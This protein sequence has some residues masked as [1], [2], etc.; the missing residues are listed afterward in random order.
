VHLSILAPR[1]Y[2]SGFPRGVAG[3]GL[4]L[5]RITAG[6]ALI[7]QSLEWMLSRVHPL[8]F[9]LG[10]MIGLAF[11]ALVVAGLFTRIAGSIAA[12]ASLAIAAGYPGG[13]TG[14]EYTIPAAMNVFV[15]VAL[16]CLGPGLFSVDA[17]C[18]GPRELVIS[19]SN[20]GTG[21]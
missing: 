19:G 8:D 17:R 3:F 9:L 5:L 16:A 10:T 21:E 2:S 11:G 12:L 15:S 20:L 1:A 4:L 18:F 6:G 13:I 7:A 14:G